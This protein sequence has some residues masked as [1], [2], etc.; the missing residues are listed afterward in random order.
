M[1][2]VKFC[3]KGGIGGHTDEGGGGAEPL[4]TIDKWC[5]NISS[6]TCY[7]DVFV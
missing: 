5:I 4:K 1:A 7:I 2:N 3:L 6:N